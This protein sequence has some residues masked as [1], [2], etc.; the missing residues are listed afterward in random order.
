MSYQDQSSYPAAR[1]RKLSKKNSNGFS[2]DFSNGLPLERPKSMSTDGLMK[3]VASQ[4][5][6]VA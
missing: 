2:N 6:L 4:Q 5:K 1:Q 3:L